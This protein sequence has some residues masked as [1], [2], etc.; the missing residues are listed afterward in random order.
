MQ[1]WYNCVRF[2]LRQNCLTNWLIKH[3]TNIGCTA[4]CDRGHLAT[5]HLRSFRHTCDRHVSS[6]LT[7]LFILWCK[8]GLSSLNPALEG[9]LGGLN[10]FFERCLHGATTH[11][12]KGLTCLFC[13]CWMDDPDDG[14]WNQRSP[15]E[16]LDCHLIVF[17]AG[18]STWCSSSSDERLT[19]HTDD[20]ASLEL[21]ISMTSSDGPTSFRPTISQPSSSL[22]GAASLPKSDVQCWLWTS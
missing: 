16:G 10:H 9:P 19:S 20:S 18:M 6:Q 2:L 14:C 13:R 11:R 15:K 5:T 12:D 21:L 7:W 17:Y 22:T 8:D 3:I 4:N 1:H